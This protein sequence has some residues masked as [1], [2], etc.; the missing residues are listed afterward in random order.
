MKIGAHERGAQVDSRLLDP[1]SHCTLLARPPLLLLPIAR[2]YS[3]ALLAGAVTGTC[4]LSLSSLPLHRPVRRLSLCGVEDPSFLSFASGPPPILVFLL[5]ER[6]FPSLG[7]FCFTGSACLDDTGRPFFFRS[8]CL[9]AA[10]ERRLS[11]PSLC[12]LHI[13]SDQNW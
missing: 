8:A 5:L 3:C 2:R 13:S 12:S 7:L 9:R 6:H 1:F 11:V 4:S 10:D